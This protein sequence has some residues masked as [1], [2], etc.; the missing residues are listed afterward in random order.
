M[1]KT[2]TRTPD[3]L[4]A[5]DWKLYWAAPGDA[6][7]GAGPPIFKRCHKL[8]RECSVC[9]LEFEREQGYLVRAMYLS[10]TFASVAALSSTVA[11]PL[12][13]CGP[14]S[15][16]VLSCMVL[17]AF[18]PFL[19]RYPRALWLCLDQVVAPR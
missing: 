18:V 2:V 19:F 12:L 8:N 9:G 1:N 16:Y 7:R 6:V 13:G 10:N 4:D 3:Q 17:V 14:A 11:M 5:A 15:I